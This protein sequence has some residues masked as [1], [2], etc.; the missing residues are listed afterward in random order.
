MHRGWLLVVASLGLALLAFPSLASPQ[1]TH[2]E[3]LAEKFQGTLEDI[4][5]EMPGVLGI[6][7][8]DLTTN[9]RFGINETLV[10][11]QGSAIKVSILV[12]MYVRQARGELDVDEAI[13]IR[14]ADRVG[15]SGYLRHFGDGTSSLSH[16]DLAVL[17]IT[18]SDNMATNMLIDRVGMSEVT[19]IMGQL[20]F[21][22][23]RLQRKM[24]H[25]RESAKGIENL[26]TP[27][28]AAQL[29]ARIL[30]CD[31]PV[32]E[33][34]CREMQEILAIP[35]AGPIQDGTP[36][37]VRVLQKTGSITGVRT[38]WGVVD[39]EG[40]PYTLAVMGNFGET[41]EISA[42]IQEVAEAAHWYFSRLAGATAHGTRVP[43]QLLERPKR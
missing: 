17:M 5:W 22:D 27:A 14:A 10:F 18:I 38:S 9:R 43:L 13:Q 23:T 1:E 6:S 42:A 11:P 20:G 21:P 34:D 12:A 39:L 30:R 26:S 28:Q 35:H 15:G 7:V 37:G 32:D 19:R 3:L 41:A 2:R 36:R 16:H 8:I 24:I 33:A 40:A 29:M 4:A 25:P 31:L